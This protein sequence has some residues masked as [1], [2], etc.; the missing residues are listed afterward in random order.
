MAAKKKSSGGKKKK[1]RAPGGSKKGR[2]KKKS[3]SALMWIVTLVCVLAFFGGV[4]FYQEFAKS[5]APSPVSGERKA[6]VAKKATKAP[7][8]AQAKKAVKKAK[9]TATAAK[10][11]GTR[12]IT[13]YFVDLR[14]NGLRAERRRVQ[15]GSLSKELSGA[16]KGLISGSKAAYGDV[17]PRG[18]RLL[19]VKMKSGVAYVNLSR[20][21]IENH[22]G[23]SSAEINS[24][25]A[26]VNTVALNFDRVSLV[27]LLVDGEKIDTIAG[28]IY[29]GEPLEADES[30]VLG[31]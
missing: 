19:S 7:K 30:I 29:I 9:A 16:V 8:A 10:A 4:F 24:V 21:F 11:P 13:L 22:W 5:Y 23:G 26:L 27:Q 17:L 14:G 28:H 12:E 25:Y 3:G 2:G 6:R 31:G 18:T 15:S 1:G 20:E